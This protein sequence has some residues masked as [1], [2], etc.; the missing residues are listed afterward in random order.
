MTEDSLATPAHISEARRIYEVMKQDKEMFKVDEDGNPVYS[1]Q[2]ARDIKSTHMALVDEINEMCEGLKDQLKGWYVSVW[3]M[4]E[5]PDE[6]D[7]MVA[8]SRRPAADI[9]VRLPNKKD[10]K[11]TEEEY[12]LSGDIQP[13][14]ASIRTDLYAMEF[15]RVCPFDFAQLGLVKMLHPTE[16]D[17][18]GLPK[19]ILAHF[20]YILNSAGRAM[21]ELQ[22]IFM[23][24]TAPGVPIQEAARKAVDVR[25]F[26]RQRS[27]WEMS[28]SQADFEKSRN[29]DYGE[30]LEKDVK[31]LA[32]EYLRRTKQRQKEIE[33]SLEDKI[34]DWVTANTKWIVILILGLAAIIGAIMILTGGVTLPNGD[35]EPDVWTGDGI[36]DVILWTVAQSL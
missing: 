3:E 9:P 24:E 27:S 7:F 31:D 28:I 25:M 22:G 12:L 10:G 26:E 4:I 5:G 6:F 23:D 8:L 14:R 2:S 15:S 20:V 21:A 29:K 11:D 16:K 1:L 19:V 32:A 35:G 17:S 30:Q 36:K 33:K 34:A 13:R 18:K